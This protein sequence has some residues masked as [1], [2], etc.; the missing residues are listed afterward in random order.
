[1]MTGRVIVGLNIFRIRYD[2]NNYRVDDNY[3]LKQDEKQDLKKS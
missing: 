2:L 3:D 1:M